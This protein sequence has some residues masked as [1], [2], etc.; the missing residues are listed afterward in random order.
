MKTK[1]YFPIIFFLI[2]IFYITSLQISAQ[3]VVT[4]NQNTNLPVFSGN[5]V[6]KE[7]G[8]VLNFRQIY[9]TTFNG[10]PKG[11]TII[12][13]GRLFLLTNEDYLYSVNV[14]TGRIMWSKKV[15]RTSIAPPFFQGD[16]LYIASLNKQLLKINII[17]GSV[18]WEKYFN[19]QILGCYVYYGENLFCGGEDGKLYRISEKYGEVT[20]VHPIDLVPSTYGIYQDNIL[21]LP[22]KNNTLISYDLRDMRLRYKFETE[23]DIITP[24]LVGPDFIYFADRRKL[25]GINKVTG[26]VV[27]I[28]RIN[29]K[30][31]NDLAPVPRYYDNRIFLSTRGYDY[32]TGIGNWVVFGK[33]KKLTDSF[34]AGKY[35]YYGGELFTPQNDNSG[36][37]EVWD[38]NKRER[39][40]HFSIKVIPNLSLTVYGKILFFIG[41]DG[42]LYGFTGN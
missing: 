16:F 13:N 2:S 25:Y 38:I 15:E 28:R 8:P 4:S 12:Y 1:K 22:G 17:S 42:I 9:A 3:G 30:W 24:V 35:L 34:I 5:N 21:Y 32:K 39:L 40:Y 41:N 7:Q 36:F 20:S 6:Q 10:T 18:I 23:T 31:F 26:R 14:N 29:M 37:I 11:F 19:A 27:W 33:G